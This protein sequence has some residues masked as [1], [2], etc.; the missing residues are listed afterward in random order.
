MAQKGPDWEWATVICDGS[1]AVA[2]VLGDLER[3]AHGPGWRLVETV[4]SGTKITT[5][6]IRPEPVTVPVFMLIIKRPYFHK[7]KSPISDAKLADGN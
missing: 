1:D 5:E 3:G 4:F 2:R 6:V 7:T